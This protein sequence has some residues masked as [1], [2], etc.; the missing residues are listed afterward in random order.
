MNV[1]QRINVLVQL[2]IYMQTNSEEWIAVKQKAY[3][4]NQWFI[5]QFIELAIHNICTNFLKSDML[6]KVAHHYKIGEPGN[7]KNVGIVMAGNIPLVGFHDF[8]CVFISGHQ[9]TIKLSSKD[10]VLLPFLFKKIKDWDDEFTS[11]TSVAE[12]LKGCDAYIAT[13]SNNSG[14]YFDY[15]FRK[16]PH[17]IRKNRTSVAV[18]KGNETNE[19]LELLADDVCLYFGLGCRNVTKLFAPE[20]YNFIPFLE[21]LKK[22]EYFFEFNKYKNN[23]DYH[24][25]LL[26]MSNK[27]YMTNGFVLLTEN[28]SLFAPVSQLNFSFYNSLEET[29]SVLQ[30]N[31]NIQCIVGHH[32][33]AFGNAQKP[34]LT[35]FADGADTLLLLKEL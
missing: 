2:G 31:N 18:L 30:N 27:F 12:T 7:I 1:Q 22:Y 17:I 25:A 21:A 14:R 34:A 24:L 11:H 16:Y 5:P 23:Y 13:G 35:D 33:T 15:Y 6:E 8:L 20:G 19:E 4:Q 32:H 9:A 26:I 29:V 28:V 3:L 10:D